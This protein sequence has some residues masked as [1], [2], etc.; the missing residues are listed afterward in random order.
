MWLRFKNFDELRFSLG[1]G[2]VY[3]FQIIKVAVRLGFNERKRLIRVF[4]FRSGLFDALV[5]TVYAARL[6]F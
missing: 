4:S 5:L 1:S 6:A 2:S 3:V